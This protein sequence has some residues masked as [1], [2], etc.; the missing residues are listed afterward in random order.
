MVIQHT[1]RVVSREV[2]QYG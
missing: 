1:L 2:M